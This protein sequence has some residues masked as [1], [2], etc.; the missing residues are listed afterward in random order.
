MMRRLFVGVGELEQRGFAVGWSKER[1]ADGQIVAGKARRDGHRR[2][3][4]QKRVQRGNAL[5]VHVG[6][7]DPILYI[8]G[9]VLDGFVD[10]RV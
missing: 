7:I 6:R 10:D 2:G 1:D 8:C 9:L 4:H 3:I 5:V